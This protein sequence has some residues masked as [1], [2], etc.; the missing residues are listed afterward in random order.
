MRKKSEKVEKVKDF[1]KRLGCWQVAFAIFAIG[2]IVHLFFIQVVDLKKLRLKAKKQ[3][4]AQSFVMRGD[5]YDRNGIK[6]ASDKILFDVYARTPD[7]EHTPEELAN[8]LAP[9]LKIPK[10][11]LVQKL[12]RKDIMISLKKNV[13]R[14]T[15]D[16]IAKLHLREIPMD[17]K[18]TRVY[19]QGA[20]AAHVLGYYNFDA[21]ISAGIEK[22]AKDKLELVDGNVSIERTPKG[23]IIYDV[24]TD[25]LAT[26]R[27]MKGEDITLTIDTAI[28]H[29][30]EQELL[31]V[32][33]K[34]KALR[35]TVIVV[36]PKNGEILA[37][38]VYPYYDPNNF[39]KATY[40]QIKNWPLTDVFPPGSTFK[41]ITVASAMDLG[42]INPS[43]KIND[44]GKIKVGWWDIE[45]YDYKIRP[46]PGWI[47][48][49]YLFEHSSNVAS[50]KVAQM[51]TSKEFY[52]MLKKFGIGA[53]TGIDLPGE[54]RGILK[55]ANKWDSSDHASMG[56][57]YGAS[58]TAIQMVEAV[59]ALANNGVRVTPH[60]IKY[61][62]EEADAK[63]HYTQV[64]KPETAKNVTKILMESINQGKS[65]IKMEK[66]NVAAKTGT[67]KK[68]KEDGSGYTSKYYTSIVGY[69][70][71]TDPEILIYV[72]VDSAQGGNVWGS[73]IA[74]PIFKEISS[75]VARIM[76]LKPDKNVG[77][78]DLNKKS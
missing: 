63:I 77:S 11:T 50:V 25:P 65:P 33:T 35:G 2:L 74:A 12:K 32:V 40:K 30:C 58:V 37:Y 41:V 39:K 47:T 64:L 26:T 55:P 34:T 70:P 62:Q 66:Y 57:G 5:I 1:D 23:D 36:N 54:S 71:A 18:T 31:K 49:E 22:T 38:A 21:D 29:V 45:N 42:K 10:S 72:M 24:N 68:P 28:Q 4:S 60:I 17:K 27:P 19:P 53:I 3:R 75:Q 69:L 9:I 73:T 61:S 14:Q 16:E 44:T 52:D 43:T 15:R 76:N 56:Y 20:L 78:I 48:L 46:N 13:D 6:L 7:Y 59:S 51:M 67:S 8:M